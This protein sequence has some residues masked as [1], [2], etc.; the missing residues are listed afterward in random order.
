MQAR[1]LEKK[2]EREREERKLTKEREKIGMRSSSASLEP[3]EAIVG[4]KRQQS[5][6]SGTFEPGPSRASD[7]LIR[8]V[9]NKRAEFGAFAQAVPRD[10]KDEEEIP[11]DEKEGKDFMYLEGNRYIDDEDGLTYKVFNQLNMY[12][13]VQL[14]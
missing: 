9:R 3:T 6:T 13:F 12:N 5:V 11:E 7:A 8:D 1:E 2:V 14:V 4:K 10:S